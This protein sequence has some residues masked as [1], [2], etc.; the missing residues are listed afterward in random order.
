MSALAFVDILEEVKII[1]HE[2]LFI[3]DFLSPLPH[4][5]HLLSTILFPYLQA[6]LCWFPLKCAACPWSSVDWCAWPDSP[7]ARTSSSSELGRSGWE[8]PGTGESGSSSASWQSRAEQSG[9]EVTWDQC[10]QHTVRCVGQVMFHDFYRLSLWGLKNSLSMVTLCA[11]L[12]AT[13]S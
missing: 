1:S 9:A 3:L 8:L 12:P 11:P 4:L 7:P 5:F 13:C 10:D 2:C 6:Q